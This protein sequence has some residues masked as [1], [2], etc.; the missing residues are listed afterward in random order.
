MANINKVS[1]LSPVGYLGGANWNGRG[2]MYFI[3][4][5]DGNAF[6]PGDPVKLSGNGDTTRGIT[7]VTL[8]TAGATCVGV[9]LAAGINP[10]GG[11]YIDP[12]N[13]TLT[14]VPATK[15]QAYYALVADDPDTIFEIQEGGAGANLTSAA[16]GENI[17]FVA[18]APATGVRVSGFYANNNAHDTTSTRNLKL[19]RLAQRIDNA[20]GQ[21]A[22]WWVLIN[23][24]SFRVGVTGI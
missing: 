6:S 4:S 1:G 13:L 17:D 20:F 14:Q 21:Y 10:S 11:P 23:N 22:K 3:D 2:S 8:A 5:A 19:L 12:N 24:H 7:G 9:L 16:L 15:A 18:A